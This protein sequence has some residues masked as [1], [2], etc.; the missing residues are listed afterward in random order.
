MEK[1]YTDEG[2]IDNKATPRKETNEKSQRPTS[3][4]K[5]VKS[6]RGS[7]KDKC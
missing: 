3:E 6:D 4:Q 2:K 7:F 1:G 5:S